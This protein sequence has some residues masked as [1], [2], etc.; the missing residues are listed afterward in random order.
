MSDVNL[1]LSETATL[2]L[3]VENCRVAIARLI[4]MGMPLQPRNNFGG[5]YPS[6]EDIREGLSFYGYQFCEWADSEN[7]DIL[8]KLRGVGIFPE[9][10]FQENIIKKYY[11]EE[12]LTSE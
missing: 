11:P 5:M 1:R 4:I 2:H 12:D 8:E 9:T 7:S 3:Q 6:S 10:W